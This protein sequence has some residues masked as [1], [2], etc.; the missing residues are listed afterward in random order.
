MGDRVRSVR[1]LSH[2][3]DDRL[4][5]LND[6]KRCVATLWSRFDL[7]RSDVRRESDLG[8]AL[9]LPAR[10]DPSPRQKFVEP[11]VG[12]EIDQAGEDL[13]ER[14]VRLDVV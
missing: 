12:P 4:K 14:G 10:G 3:I 2:D 9:V 8:G 6:R 1:G 7:R 11:F 13:G 5:R